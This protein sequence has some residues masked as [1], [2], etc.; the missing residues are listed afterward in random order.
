MRLR[1]S[2]SDDEAA[3]SAARDTL[4]SEVARWLD[5]SDEERAEVVGD[6]RIFLDWRYNYSTGLLDEFTDADIEEFLLGWCP[7]KLSV[8][9]GQSECVCR[10]VG[11]YIE[12]MADT[13]RLVGGVGHARALSELARELAPAMREA[14]DDP[15]NFGM[16]KSLFAGLG[17]VSEMS[18]EPCCRFPTPNM[19]R[20]WLLGCRTCPH[21]SGFDCSPRRSR[22]CRLPGPG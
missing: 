6:I 7:R 19:N 3:F 20:W 15:A 12:F 21:L 10:A 1:F 14:M 2:P 5:A 8:P 11:A 13:Q 4:L 22:P 16:A 17:D 9:P 18:D